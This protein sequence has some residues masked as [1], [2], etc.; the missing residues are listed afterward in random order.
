MFRCS[1]RVFDGREAIRS[2]LLTSDLSP[3]TGARLPSRLLMPNVTLRTLIADHRTRHGF[4]EDLR[5]A[6]PSAA[7]LEVVAA[8][9]TVDDELATMAR[10]MAPPAPVVQRVRSRTCRLL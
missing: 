2:W 7:A 10:D 4:A 1:L 8:A 3:M 9:G 6:R 5:A